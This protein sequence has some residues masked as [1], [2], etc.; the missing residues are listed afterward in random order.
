MQPP[1]V[2]VAEA[3]KNNGPFVGTSVVVGILKRDEVFAV[4][5]VEL[6]VAPEG[7]HGHDEL[8]LKH[9]RG[10][11]PTVGVAVF[12][13]ADAALAG[14]GGDFPIE[15]Q[16]RRFGHEQSAAVVERV[17]NLVPNQGANCTVIRCVIRAGI[18]KWSLQDA[19]WEIDT[20]EVRI[21]VR[22]RGRRGHSP[23]STVQGLIDL[24][25]LTLQFKLAGPEGVSNRVPTD[26][27]KAGVIAP[28]FRIADL[29]FDSGQ[30][31]FR[32]LL[33]DGR[34]PIQLVD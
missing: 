22:I 19:S 1:V 20:V 6:A 13:Q 24:G 31:R 5:D 3:V 34:H 32:F 15:V 17:S 29:A 10:L 12:E 7:A 25:Q 8:V 11:V 18:E 30:F 26:D 28:M 21:V 16:A 27:Q 4:G 14:E 23:L 2:E 9:S 33:G